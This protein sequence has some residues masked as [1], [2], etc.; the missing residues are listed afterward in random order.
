MSVRDRG[1]ASARSQNRDGAGAY[2]AERIANCVV[3]VAQQTLEVRLSIAST[4]Y[5]PTL[6]SGVQHYNAAAPFTEP[7]RLGPTTNAARPP[8]TRPPYTVTPVRTAPSGPLCT[9]RICCSV[10]CRKRCMA[11]AFSLLSTPAMLVVMSSRTPETYLAV[12]YGDAHERRACGAPCARRHG[13]TRSSV[14]NSRGP[15]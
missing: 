9:A 10:F 3:G 8:C 4:T 12:T 6:R 13:P 2:E 7:R 5:P 15:C 11:A 1:G 14:R